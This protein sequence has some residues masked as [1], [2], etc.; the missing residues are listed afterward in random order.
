MAQ[1]NI[2]GGSRGEPTREYKTNFFHSGVKAIGL[3]NKVSHRF[4]ILPAFDR[5]TFRPEDPGF[6]TSFVSYRDRNLQ[7]DVDTKT[8][9]FTDWYFLFQAHNY[10]AR[11]SS[12][13][14]VR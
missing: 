1:L 13:S 11:R 5:N 7:P 8:E 4:R 10:L 3:N 14:S 12:R 6:K 2:P 9:G